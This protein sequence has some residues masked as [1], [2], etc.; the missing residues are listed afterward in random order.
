MQT[1]T[2]PWHKVLYRKKEINTKPVGKSTGLDAI[3][4]KIIKKKSGDHILGHVTYKISLSFHMES[5]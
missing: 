3:S 2:G 5:C 4:V 1:E